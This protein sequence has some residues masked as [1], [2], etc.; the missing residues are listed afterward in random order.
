[1]GINNMFYFK[2]AW[3]LIDIYMLRYL[4]LFLKK[5]YNHWDT[6]ITW[7]PQKKCNEHLLQCS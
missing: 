6:R 2:N 7:I 5:S 1:M 3:G 4:Q